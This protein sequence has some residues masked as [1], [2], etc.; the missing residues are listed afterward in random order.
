MA[1]KVSELRPCD[2]CGG[3]IAPMFYVLR[4]SLA[5]I[6]PEAVNE[7]VGM[8]RFFQGRASAALVENFAP[9]SVDAVTVAGDQAPE[10]MTELWLCQDCYLMKPIDLAQLSE[11]RAHR[12]PQEAHM[13]ETQE[14]AGTTEETKPADTPAEAEKPA[15]GGDDAGTTATE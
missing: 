9:R 2:A 4:I 3:P 5:L 10:L 13:E 1:I 7:F 12:Q 15:E 8:H 6:N 14:G 11:Q